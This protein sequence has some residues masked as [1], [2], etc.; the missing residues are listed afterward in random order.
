MSDRLRQRQVFG[1]AAVLMSCWLLTAC[2]GSLFE[3]Q[4]PAATRYVIAP[5]PPAATATAS[6]ASQVDL[7]VGRPDVTPGLDT[8]RIAVLRGHELDYY[9]GALWSGTLLDMTQ[10]FLVTAL[11][12]QKLFRNVAAEQARVAGEYLLDTEVRAFQAEYTGATAPTVRVT[13]IGRVIRIRDRKMI[14]TVAATAT[15]P[16]GENR[17]TAVA[18]A[19]EAAMQR[20]SLEIANRSAAIIAAD[21]VAQ[22]VAQSRS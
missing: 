7:A 19:F 16:A 13:I 10:S 14:D 17:L 6:A 8:D 21:R 3:S 4:L 15:Q 1:T 11:G 5:P 9:R 18:T 12:D 20:V 22:P 2:G